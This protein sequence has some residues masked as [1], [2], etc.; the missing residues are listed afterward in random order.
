MK[1]TLASAKARLPAS[2]ITEGKTHY[3][4][5]ADDELAGVITRLSRTVMGLGE[6]TTSIGLEARRHFAALLAEAT[7]ER[8]RRKA[9]RS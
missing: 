6:S 9:R 4:A 2:W 5:L 8:D 3:C 1:R 7:A